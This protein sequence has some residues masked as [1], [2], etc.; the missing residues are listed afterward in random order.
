MSYPISRHQSVRGTGGKS[1]ADMF[2]GRNVSA[3]PGALRAPGIETVT[4][5]VSA[6][7]AALW[8]NASPVRSRVTAR[9]KPEVRWARG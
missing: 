4:T 3:R 2:G 9:I 8:S 5:R 6:N 7:A 1:M